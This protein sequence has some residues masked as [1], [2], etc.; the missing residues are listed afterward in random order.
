M[1]KRPKTLD[2]SL[3]KISLDLETPAPPEVQIYIKPTK[4]RHF[5]LYGLSDQFKG[6]VRR[7][8]VVF[9]IPANEGDLNRPPA[10]QSIKIDTESLDLRLRKMKVLDKG[11]FI[12]WG[13]QEYNAEGIMESI[14]FEINSS[15]ILLKYRST[16]GTRRICQINPYDGQKLFD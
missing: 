15:G 9:L 11:Y 6:A 4:A 2:E 1:S 16:T 7:D 13:P 5:E 14:V 10:T 3:T 12:L 8:D